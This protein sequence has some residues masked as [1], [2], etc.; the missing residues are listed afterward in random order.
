MRSLYPRNCQ[1]NSL[2]LNYRG[3]V[4]DHDTSISLFLDVCGS[5]SGWVCRLA[6]RFWEVKTVP[7]SCSM[8]YSRL[9]GCQWELTMFNGNGHLDRIFVNFSKFLKNA[10]R[11]PLLTTKMGILEYRK[12]GFRDMFFSFSCFC[13]IV[14]CLVYLGDSARRRKQGWVGEV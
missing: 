12:S 7:N 4:L 2:E 8:S 10:P 5:F 13:K 9:Q 6:L 3:E 11:R 1:E 14:L